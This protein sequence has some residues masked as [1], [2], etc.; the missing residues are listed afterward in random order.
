MVDSYVEY[1]RFD[2]NV[3]MKRAEDLGNDWAEKDAA[4]GMLED[5]KKTL[6]ATLIIPEL[7]E[8]KPTS[9]ALYYAHAKPEFNEHLNALGKARREKNLALVKYNTYKK[10]IDLCQTKEANQRAEMKIR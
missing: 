5:H 4:F 7:D 9:K 1:N 2:P 3:L 10:W 8:G 6:E